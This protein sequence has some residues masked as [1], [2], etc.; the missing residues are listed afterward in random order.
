MWN[1]FTNW[2]VMRVVFIPIKGISTARD[3]VSSLLNCLGKEHKGY[4][5]VGDE[6]GVVTNSSKGG[7]LEASMANK[8]G[9]IKPGLEIHVDEFMPYLTDEIVKELGAL[10]C[11]IEEGV[12][13]SKHKQWC[14]M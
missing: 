8:L 11:G 2:G 1:L 14:A 3:L 9:M 13:V 10:T 5:R 4:K 7:V 6:G 12:G